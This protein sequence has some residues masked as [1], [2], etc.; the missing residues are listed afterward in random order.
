LQCFGIATCGLSLALFGCPQPGTAV[1]DD[2]DSGLPV[3][4]NTNSGGGGDTDNTGDVTDGRTVVVDRNALVRP[5]SPTLFI[6]DA[7]KGIISFANINVADGN[8]APTTFIDSFERLRQTSDQFPMTA[9]AVCVDR[10]GTLIVNDA[11]PALRFYNNAAKVT[12]IPAPNREIGGLGS[13]L[14]DS[15]GMTYDRENDRLF[16]ATSDR[17]LIFEGATLK[18]NGEVAP[19]RLFSSPDL[20]GG[21]SIA[22]G[23]NGDLYMTDLLEQRILVFANAGL[24]SGEIRADRVIEL[25]IISNVVCVDSSD[26]L[27]VAG[28]TGDV[29]AVVDK[30]S[31]LD[32]EV[33][34]FRE[35]RLSG[36]R[37]IDEAGSAQPE[38]EALVVDSRGI[39]Y[40][41]DRANAAIHVIDNIGSRTG[42][43]RTDRAIHGPAVEF[44]RALAIFLWE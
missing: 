36:V 35:M 9:L 23:P 20:P 30:A 8:V 39:G 3:T 40:V 31:S 14:A 7:N 29:I 26:R 33:R 11:F 24:R 6:A 43:I 37:A 4:G 1:D 28:A 42:D 27:Y 22:L 44:I 10:T 2:A 5:N 18:Q 32:G 34:D 13:R 41:A 21:G 17:V 15:L 38:I 25:F 19:T 12:G 16:V